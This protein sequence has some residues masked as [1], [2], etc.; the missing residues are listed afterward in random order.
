MVDCIE[1]SAKENTNVDK[2]FKMLAMQ[3]VAKYGEENIIDSGEESLTLTQQ[4][5][6]DVYGYWGCCGY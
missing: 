1:T 2:C 3:L 5:T 4:G 6:S